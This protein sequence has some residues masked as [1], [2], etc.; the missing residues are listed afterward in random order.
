MY[1]VMYQNSVFVLISVKKIIMY[2]G[3][4]DVVSVSEF[5]LVSDTILGANLYLT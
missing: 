1:V 4:C 5:E 3:M 2:T